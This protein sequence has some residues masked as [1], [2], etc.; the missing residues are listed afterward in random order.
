M[1]KL[2]L[3]LN[4][5]HEFNN[6]LWLKTVRLYWTGYQSAAVAAEYDS[7]DEIYSEI[8]LQANEFEEML[9]K[10]FQMTTKVGLASN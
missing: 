4:I 5:Y 6:L 2:T 10:E 3:L 9:Q 8:G 7:L 1:N